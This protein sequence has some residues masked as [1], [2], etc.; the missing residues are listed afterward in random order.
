[1]LHTGFSI[2]EEGFF[3]CKYYGTQPRGMTKTWSV[4]I[5]MKDQ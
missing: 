3:N 2:S 1:M 4:D 5:L